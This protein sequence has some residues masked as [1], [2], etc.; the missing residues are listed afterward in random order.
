MTEETLQEQKLRLEIDELSANK[1]HS[2][3]KLWVSVIGAVVL[4]SGLFLERYSTLEQRMGCCRT[5]TC[6]VHEG[7]SFLQ[8]GQTHLNFP[9]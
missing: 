3:I 4:V 8:S 7:Q 5:P 9:F 1:K 2:N 6:L